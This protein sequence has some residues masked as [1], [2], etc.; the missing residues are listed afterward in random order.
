MI[1]LSLFFFLTLL[2]YK[3]TMAKIVIF[4]HEDLS[5]IKSTLAYRMDEYRNELTKKASEISILIDYFRRLEGAIESDDIVLLHQEMRENFERVP[6]MWSA[7]EEIVK[8]FLLDTVHLNMTSSI[9]SEKSNPLDIKTESG[10][11]RNSS[12]SSSYESVFQILLHVKRDYSPECDKVRDIIYGS[13]L[14]SL[15][16]LGEDTRLH[17]EKR[18]LVPGAGIGRLALELAH[19]GY[20][21][22]ANEL[23]RSMTVVFFNMFNIIESGTIHEYYPNL[24]LPYSDDWDF[25][26]RLQS[27]VFPDDGDAVK[28]W[29]DSKIDGSLALQHSM[30][31]FFG[32]DVFRDY[33]DVVASSFFIDTGNLLKNIA[34]IAHTLKKDGIW[35]NAGPLHYHGPT[36]PY[37]HSEVKRLAVAFGFELLNEEQ[38]ETDYSGESSA[39]MKPEIYRFPLT[40]WR[41]GNITKR[42]DLQKVYNVGEKSPFVGEKVNDDITSKTSPFTPNFKL[43]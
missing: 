9:L 34:I 29:R 35:I 36:I 2:F 21:V 18:V 27:S 26:K 41:L 28:A 33:F 13:M 38:L 37:S 7:N 8:N 6:L 31:S 22:T 39:S 25:A 10:H 5:K 4:G 3:K 43:L 14:K 40:V 19:A 23:S 1:Q 24:H 30:F 12:T 20:H 16:D 42:I 15:S 11:D 17:S 32:D